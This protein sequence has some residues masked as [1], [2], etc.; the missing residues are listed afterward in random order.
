MWQ[1]MPEYLEL[2][3]RFLNFCRSFQCLNKYQIPQTS[4]LGQSAHKGGMELILLALELG[5]SLYL[6]RF[7]ILGMQYILNK[8]KYLLIN[9]STGRRSNSLNS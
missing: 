1:N 8:K 5:L 2:R 7:N 6:V 9:A 3:E 4:L